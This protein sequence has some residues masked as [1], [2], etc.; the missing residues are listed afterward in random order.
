MSK[1]VC[2][3]Y[4]FAGGTLLGTEVGMRC[5]EMQHSVPLGRRQTERYIY[6]AETDRVDRARVHQW[7]TEQSYWVQGRAREKQ[8]AAVDASRN[9]G[10]YD[11][12]SGEPVAYGR[13]MLTGFTPNTASPG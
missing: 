10:A 12:G 1:L 7:L 6:S 8:D 4:M 13:A 9:Y 11:I 2:T 5:F 3:Q